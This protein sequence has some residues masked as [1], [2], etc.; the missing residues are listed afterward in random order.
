MNQ[1]INTDSKNRSILTSY[2][3]FVEQ[4]KMPEWNQIW[5]W[6]LQQAYLTSDQWTYTLNRIMFVEKHHKF[7]C[8]YVS[9]N[10]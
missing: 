8:I 9:E 6:A 5:D 7:Q 10:S 3:Y 1:S 4:N 2:W